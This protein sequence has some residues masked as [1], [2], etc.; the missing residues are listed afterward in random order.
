MP[1]LEHGKSVRLR[2]LSDRTVV[3]RMLNPYFSEDPALAVDD[4]CFSTCRP[5]AA[6]MPRAPLQW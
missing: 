3:R 1:V 5:A 6:R 4:Q 2:L